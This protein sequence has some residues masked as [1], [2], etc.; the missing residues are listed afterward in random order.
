MNIASNQDFSRETM[1]LLQS[2]IH[3]VNPFVDLFKS[4]EELCSEREGVLEGIRMVFRAENAPVPRRYNAPTADEVGMLIVSGDYDESD[5]EPR[6]RDIVVRFKGVEG[7]NGLSR[8]SELYQ[9]YDALHYVL[10][11]LDTLET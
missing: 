4:M 5:L 7:N 9:H 8:I 1:R 11:N 2:M 10:Q 6:N 3:E